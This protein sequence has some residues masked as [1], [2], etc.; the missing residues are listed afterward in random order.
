M[1]P[2]RTLPDVM[3]E[4]RRSVLYRYHGIKMDEHGEPIEK[5]YEYQAEDSS[6]STDDWME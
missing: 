4:S 6:D 5:H 3:V 1:V 2:L